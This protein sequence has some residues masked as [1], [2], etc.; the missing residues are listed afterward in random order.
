MLVAV[1]SKR[2][3]AARGRRLTAIE[4][5]PDLLKRARLYAAAHDTTLRVLVEEGLRWRLGQ[6]PRKEDK[7]MASRPRGRRGDTP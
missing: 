5:P 4:L 2:S 1:A 3:P 7:A 6:T